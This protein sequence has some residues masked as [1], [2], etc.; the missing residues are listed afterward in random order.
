MKPLALFAIVVTFFAVGFSCSS[1]AQQDTGDNL[2]PAADHS[3]IQTQVQNQSPPMSPRQVAEMRAAILMARKEYSDAAIA[4]QHLLE[5]DP[6][7]ADF[8]NRTGMAYQEL[9]QDDLAQHFYKKAMRADKRF[10]E[11]IN[12]L[13]TVEYSRKRYGKAIKYYKKAIDVAPQM[14]AVY[15]NLG[16][17]YCAIK[18][19]PAAMEVFG[20]AVALDPKV[21]EHRGSSGSILQQRTAADSG[22]LYFTIAK[23]YAKLGDAERV[24]RYLKLARDG[25]YKNFLAIEKDPAFEKVIKDPRVREALGVRSAYA[26]SPV[27]QDSN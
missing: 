1:L 23:S 9:G 6:R 19:Y 13:G 8:L 3:Q 7:N 21:F 25:G 15:S 5:T 4:Y 22:G 12:N 17:A 27:K 2:Q 16:Y 10:S 14:A 11:A 20:K 24:A 26:A 18:K